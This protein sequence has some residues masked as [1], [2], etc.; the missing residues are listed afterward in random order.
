[1]ISGHLQCLQYLS[2]LVIRGSFVNSNSLVAISRLPHLVNLQ[3]NQMS[4]RNKDLPRVL[5]AAQLSDES[6]PA[7]LDLRLQSCVLDDVMAVWDKAPLVRSLTS[8]FL[9]LTP[10]AGQGIDSV[11]KDPGSFFLL[12]VDVALVS[13]V[14]SCTETRCASHCPSIL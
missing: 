1:M 6:F 4:D 7:L 8:F 9:K 12:Y 5:D 10:P 11:Y 2:N 3:I 14:S 13:D